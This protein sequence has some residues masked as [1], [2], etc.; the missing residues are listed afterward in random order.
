MK[1][2]GYSISINVLILLGILYLIM[3]VNALS[4]SCNR[5]GMSASDTSIA[6]QLKQLQAT[7]QNTPKPILPQQKQ[8]F[9]TTLNML[10]TNARDNNLRNVIN[11]IANQLARGSR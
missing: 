6:N 3:V 9:Y 2:F 1:V 11:Q 5:E 10:G 7:I 4:G 8:Q